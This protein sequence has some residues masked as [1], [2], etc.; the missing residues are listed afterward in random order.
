M[1]LVS[2][3]DKNFQTDDYAI[4]F[5]RYVGDTSNTGKFLYDFN[6]SRINDFC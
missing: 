2:L 6:R 1:E 4:K 5:I 3:F